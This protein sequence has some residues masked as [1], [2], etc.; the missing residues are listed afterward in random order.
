M[1]RN[2]GI[3]VIMP[4]EFKC[5]NRC[6]RVLWDPLQNPLNIFEEASLQLCSVCIHP[7]INPLICIFKYFGFLICF[8]FGASLAF[9]QEMHEYLTFAARLFYLIAMSYEDLSSINIQ[10]RQHYSSKVSK[11]FNLFLNKL[12]QTSG[13]QLKLQ[14]F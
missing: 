5:Y 11:L 9:E 13:E 10:T 12:N 4:A 7:M 8:L 3:C 14:T 2:L 1:L 6:S